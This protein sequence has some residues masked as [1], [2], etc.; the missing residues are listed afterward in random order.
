MVELKFNT[1]VIAVNVVFLLLIVLKKL[2]IHSLLFSHV[3]PL[4]FLI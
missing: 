1:V 4:Q 3:Y 2:I